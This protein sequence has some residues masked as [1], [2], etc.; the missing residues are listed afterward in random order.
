MQCHTAPYTWK[1]TYEANSRQYE[2]I[3]SACSKKEEGEWQNH[4]RSRIA[5]EAQESTERNPNSSGDLSLLL[6]DAKSLG[7]AFE[8]HNGFTRRKSIHRAATL[9]PKTNLQQV[10]IK[11]TDAQKS[12]GDASSLPVMRSQS[13]LSSSHIPILAP[14][15]AERIRLE[16]AIG[17][18]WTR[19]VLPYPGMLSRR[20]ETHIRASANSVMRKLSIASL[21]SNFSISKRSNSFTSLTQHRFDEPR[22][23]AS[24]RSLQPVSSKA[25]PTTR[26][27]KMRSSRPSPTVVDFH[28]APSAFLPEDFEL[29]PKQNLIGRRR[30]IANRAG[31]CEIGDASE[32]YVTP[33][34]MTPIGDC[35][36]SLRENQDSVN[37]YRVCQSSIP[38]YQRVA[39]PL[40]V[41]SNPSSGR[42]ENTITQHG[43]STIPG[44]TSP[45]A[46]QGPTRGPVKA[47]SL[48]FKLFTMV[49]E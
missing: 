8:A 49:K 18:V 41:A 7:P 24:Q 16:A 2:I 9:G 4:L 40:G 11:N 31:T 5:K 35:P 45:F 48:L 36:D 26:L 34:Q 22:F 3:L 21:A 29:K 19:D 25:K 44:T 13:H 38:T 1:L 6:L 47:R 43:S 37:G 28:N 33:R 12:G 42:S 27:E 23:S 46:L 32:T 17:D 20:M 14:R 15:R 39:S 30:R 10:I